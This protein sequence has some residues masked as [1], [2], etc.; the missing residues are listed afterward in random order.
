MYGVLEY[1]DA[2]SNM[3]TT[4]ADHLGDDD[5]VLMVDAHDV[6][7]Q[8]PPEALIRRF[9]E[10]NQKANG[11]LAQ[12]WGSFDD[13]PMKQTIVASAQKRCFPDN[14][15]PAELHCNAV[16]E[17]TLRQDT[18]GDWTDDP[19]D[20]TLH[21]MRPKFINSGIIMGPVR[22]MKRLFRHVVEKAERRKSE[23]LRVDSDQ[24][25]IGE[26]FGEQ[27]VWR[28]IQ[29]QAKAT[30]TAISEAATRMMQDNW[31]NHLG[32]DYEQVLSVST[33][34]EEFDGQFI[35]LD[36]KEAIRKASNKLG[37]SPA[38][39]HGV[40]QDLKSIPNPLVNIYE[41]KFPV[42][43]AWGNQS[44][45]ADFYTTA[46]PAIL[47]H[48]AKRYGAKE[49]RTTWWDKTWYFPYLRDLVKSQIQPG[50]VKPLARLLTS[51]GQLV[52]WPVSSDGMKRKVR[53]FNTTLT[54]SDSMHEMEF[55]DVC[56]DPAETSASAQHW[57]DEVYRDGKG[58]L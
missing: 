33:Y 47:H 31:E 29:R 48:N 5:L 56:K 40:P 27:S 35:P 17:S 53:E 4:H 8:L 9:H 49:R 34:Y 16:P 32:L 3:N 1:L 54:E 14:D 50:G 36:D 6:W 39:L 15:R 51:A 24:G 23:G 57:Y 11:R 42:D 12:Q 43:L 38:R 26:V 58:A 7:F 10:T 21:S 2:A 37:I 44:L 18:Y 20:L 25:L 41:N 46:V 28:N 30:R 19:W 22:D 55:S 52:Y 45:Y 13:M